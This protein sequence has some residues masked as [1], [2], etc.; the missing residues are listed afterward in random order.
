MISTKEKTAIRVLGPDE[1]SKAFPI[2]KAFHKDTDLLVDELDGDYWRDMWSDMVS[3]GIGVIVVLEADG[4]VVGALC[5]LCAPHLLAPVLCFTEA[6]W[7]IKKEWRGYGTR[8]LRF[9][10]EI[11]V[12]KGCTLMNMVHLVDSRAVRMSHFYK[13]SGY[14]PSEAPYLKEIG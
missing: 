4:E 3:R 2:A 10:E 1:V 7:Y 12:A 8:M 6:M 5:G 11:A 9:A 13:R 14:T